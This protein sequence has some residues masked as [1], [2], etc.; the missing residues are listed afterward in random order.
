[1]VHRRIRRAA[2]ALLLGA[3]V[4]ACA[5]G[6]A[7]NRASDTPAPTEDATTSSPPTTTTPPPDN[8]PGETTPAPVPTQE[9]LEPAAATG[10]ATV[11]AEHPLTDIADP[12]GLTV[13]PT[14]GDLL[15]GSRTTGKIYRVAQDTGDITEIGTAASQAAGEG[16]LLGLAAADN[17][18]FFAY[19]T[20]ESE[21][22]VVR[23]AYQEGKPEGQQMETSGRLTGLPW[24]DMRVGGALLLTPDGTLYAGVGDFGDSSAGKILKSPD[25]LDASWN[26]QLPDTEVL[27]G[28]HGSVEGL[29]FDAG[30]HVW[31]VG[32]GEDDSAVLALAGSEETLHLWT[33]GAVPSGLAYTPQRCLWV[34]MADGSLWRVPLDNTELVATPQVVL[35]VAT[36]PPPELSGEYLGLRSPAAVG[37][38]TLW[39]LAT[40]GGGTSLLKLSVS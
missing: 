13:L 21:S 37:E 40:G 12:W 36:D 28:T 23:S 14:S 35:N 16:G 34:S 29:A 10:T 30:G 8:E 15:V 25:A 18:F 33:G 24:G 27:A 4:T 5:G 17:S 19:Y 31:E 3:A 26:P 22:R 32:R 11:V 2:V 6:P 38:D 1:M 20:T 39:V 7:A 9:E